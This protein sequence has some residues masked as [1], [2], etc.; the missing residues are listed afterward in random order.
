M[1]DYMTKPVQLA[2]LKAML[3]KWLP[4]RGL[5]T[6]QPAPTWDGQP[7]VSPPADL[8]VL[9]RLLGGDLLGLDELV[10]AFRNSAGRVSAALHGAAGPNRARDMADAAH[11]LKA[12]AH[13]IGAQR[14]GD[15]CEA[16]ERA[17]E[18]G[19]V[20]ALAPL[21]STFDLEMAAVT[22]HLDTC[23]TQGAATEW[24]P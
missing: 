3:H 8:R 18:R 23:R 19:D 11:T 2:N 12:G 9:A 21:M 17:A 1:D 14:L 6:A 10:Q 22:Q 13:S 20:P 5:P 4:E 16:I 15:A 24:A 7:L